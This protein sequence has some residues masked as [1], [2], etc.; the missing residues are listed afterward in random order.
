[1]LEKGD[2]AY[3]VD[4]GFEPFHLNL[5][6]ESLKSFSLN[7]QKNAFLTT[8]AVN[9]SRFGRYCVSERLS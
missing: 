4:L 1:M 2:L 6:L 5:L 7:P 8:H 3:E 9:S